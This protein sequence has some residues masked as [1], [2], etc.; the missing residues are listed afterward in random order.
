[1]IEEK[2]ISN[3]LLEEVV[4]SSVAWM[5]LELVMVVVVFFAF[6]GMH[7]KA[8]SFQFHPLPSIRLEPRNFQIYVI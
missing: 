8:C 4:A 6:L 2:A 1:M 3:F 7:L 5:V